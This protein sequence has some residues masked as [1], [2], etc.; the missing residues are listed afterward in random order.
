MREGNGGEEESGS[1]SRQ[2]TSTNEKR[3]TLRNLVFL[4]PERIMK[5]NGLSEKG[6]A[7]TDKEATNN[8]GCKSLRASHAGSS[9]GPDE[10]PE[11]DR[12]GRKNGFSEKGAGNRKRNAVGRDNC[13]YNINFCRLYS[14]MCGPPSQEL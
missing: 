10:C 5:R 6:F 14:S 8:D 12:V 9:D 13:Q 1:R 3:K 4:V 11:C 2:G 7:Y